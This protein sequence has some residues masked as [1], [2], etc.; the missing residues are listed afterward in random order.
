MLV[1]FLILAPV[2]TTTFKKQIQFQLH[3]TL[4][5]AICGHHLI[6][7]SLS[8]TCELFQPRIAINTLPP[9]SG[10]LCHMMLEIVFL[11]VFLNVDSKVILDRKSVV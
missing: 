8:A 10:M 7:F 5:V 6:T 11:L 4:L 9:L 2:V 3:A 1:I